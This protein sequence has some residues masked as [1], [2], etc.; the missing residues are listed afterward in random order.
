MNISI[1][2]ITPGFVAEIGDLDLGR[3]LAEEDLKIVRNAFATYAVLVFPAQDLTV[4]EHL[5]FAGNFGPLERTVEIAL[6]RSKLRIGHEEIADVA[7]L[8]SDGKIW[9]EDARRRHL[10][11][12]GNRLA[13]DSSFKAPSGYASLLYA[14]SIAPVGGHTMFADLRSAGWTMSRPSFETA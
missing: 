1:F 12:M 4:D 2:P 5:A 10:S 9:R 13:L 8:S 14:R 11:M 7:N 6:G 3:P